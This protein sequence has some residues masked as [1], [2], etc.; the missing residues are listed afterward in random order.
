LGKY[1]YI[2][3]N[4]LI[5]AGLAFCKYFVAIFADISYNITKS[6]VCQRYGKD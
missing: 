4:V 5:F 1:F 2:F 6:S 3:L